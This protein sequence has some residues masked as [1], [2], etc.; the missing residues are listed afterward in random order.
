MDL[1]TFDGSH[2]FS[3]ERAA[4]ESA[5]TGDQDSYSILSLGFVIPFSVEYYAALKPAWAESGALCSPNHCLQADNFS[6]GSRR[7]RGPI[8]IVPRLHPHR[9]EFRIDLVCQSDSVAFAPKSSTL[10]KR[11]LL[12][13]LGCPSHGESKLAKIALNTITAGV[14]HRIEQIEKRQERTCYP[15]FRAPRQT[16]IGEA[17]EQRAD[18]TNCDASWSA[19]AL[20]TRSRMITKFGPWLNACRIVP[21]KI[22]Y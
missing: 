8:R 14:R 1:A 19:N 20:L 2:Q 13:N 18:P 7:L 6:P 9:V 12:T 17:V 22:A 5:D 16:L 4:H 3:G 15:Q 21:R 11:H 10:E